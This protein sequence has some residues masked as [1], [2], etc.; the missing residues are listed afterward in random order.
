MYR[1][2]VA[3]GRY[4]P[5]L[6]TAP[7]SSGKRST[8][9]CSTSASVW[10]SSPAAP[11]F[12]F[13]CFHASQ[14]TSR[15]HMR[16]YS[17]WNRRPGD[18]L[19]AAHSRRRCRTLSIGLRRAGELDPVL[20]VMPLR[21]PSSPIRS[22]SWPFPP[23]AFTALVGTMTPSD[24]RCAVPPLASGLL[25]A[26][27]RDDGGADGSLVFRNDLCPRAAPRTPPRS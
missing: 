24:F 9:Y 15:L 26:L 12:A 23:T 25:V 20:P 7:S 27:C 8:P 10:P 1:R 16:S 11:R 22:L 6:K 21:L 4:S 19:A 2:K 14:R 13:T 17:A 3:L 18:R 5:A